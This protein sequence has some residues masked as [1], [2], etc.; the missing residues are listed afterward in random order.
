VS[1]EEIEQR[2]PVVIEVIVRNWEEGAVVIV[3]EAVV[4]LEH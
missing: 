2:L 1:F 4:T 3:E